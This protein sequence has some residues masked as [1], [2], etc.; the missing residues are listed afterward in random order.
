MNE[1]KSETTV[2]CVVDFVSRK[3]KNSFQNYVFTPNNMTVCCLQRNIEDQ[4]FTQL[5]LNSGHPATN[6]TK[7]SKF[8]FLIT[9]LFS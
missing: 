6:K 4:I 7:H 2:T 1:K 8:I 3:F 9:V 5:K